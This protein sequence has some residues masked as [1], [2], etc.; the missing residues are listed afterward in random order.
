[1]QRNI[2]SAQVTG[3]E[4]ELMH[5]NKELHFR[6]GLHHVNKLVHRW[7]VCFSSE[8]FDRCFLTRLKKLARF[9][10]GHWWTKHVRSWWFWQ[11]WAPTLT[12]K[13]SMLSS[14]S[15]WVIITIG[16]SLQVFFGA[17]V[18]MYLS[19]WTTIFLK[20][21]RLTW[22]KCAKGQ[23]FYAGNSFRLFLLYNVRRLEHN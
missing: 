23:N 12:S 19:C 18:F 6:F 13:M 4:E 9:Q 10:M 8:I 7:A 16:T 3:S 20:R 17:C 11:H 2:K 21:T 15:E 14:L 22:V 5:Q 1:M